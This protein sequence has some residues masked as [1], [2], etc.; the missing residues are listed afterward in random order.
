[1]TMQ[2]QYSLPNCKLVLEGLTT[3]NPAEAVN[4]RPIVSVI[5]NVECHLASQKPITGG[6]EFL[7]HLV[8]A[9]SDYAQDYL[10]GIPHTV[11]HDRRDHANPVHLQR[12]EKNLHR[13]P[14]Q[15]QAGG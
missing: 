5:T 6:R 3:D 14:I 10:S 12:I 13:L 1:M 11:R 7:E 15:P 8:K 2:R 9:V 4:S